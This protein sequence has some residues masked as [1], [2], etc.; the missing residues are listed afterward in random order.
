MNV[1]LAGLGRAGGVGKILVQMVDEMTAPDEM[2]AQVAMGEGDNVDRLVGQK[3]Q[4]NDEPLVALAAG[5]RAPDQPLPEQ[6]Q[7]P[8]VRRPGG[9][10]PRV[11]EEEGA[12]KVVVEILAA[13]IAR[14]QNRGRFWISHACPQR[15]RPAGRRASPAF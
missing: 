14:L 1:A 7:N 2:P 12:G 9:A 5:D 6:V 15:W 13:Q 11:G 4:R 10:H 3:R 8:V